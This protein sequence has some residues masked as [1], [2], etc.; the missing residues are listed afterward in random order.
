[1]LE[2]ANAMMMN[3][4]LSVGWML[5][6]VQDKDLPERQAQF[7]K[8]VMA[9]KAKEAYAAVL[10][11][12]PVLDKKN[13]V[14]NLIAQTEKGVEIYGGATGIESLGLLQETK[15]LAFGVGVVC[16]EKS[17]LFF[18]FGWYRPR[19]DA[20]WRLQNIWFDDNGRAFSEKWR[21]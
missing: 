15:Y 4:L 20:P 6:P 12:S 3:L 19:L 11:G 9:G 13:E 10:A 16:C 1:L 2:E 7:L 18:Y 8:S 5:A 17:P 21:K 14:D